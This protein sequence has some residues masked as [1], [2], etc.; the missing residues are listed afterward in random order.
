L[1]CVPKCEAKSNCRKI[2]PNLGGKLILQ[3]EVHLWIYYMI[4]EIFEN[5]FLTFFGNLPTPA[6][7][8]SI[9]FSAITFAHLK[10]LSNACGFI[11][12]SNKRSARISIVPPFRLQRVNWQFLTWESFL[13]FAVSWG[14]HKHLADQTRFIR[15][16][17]LFSNLLLSQSSG[18]FFN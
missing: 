3:H 9:P 15:I 14:S 11:I 10:L 18:L 7:L 1:P 4:F 2:K 16:Y 5:H 17:F 13:C 12:Y 8:Y 6:Q